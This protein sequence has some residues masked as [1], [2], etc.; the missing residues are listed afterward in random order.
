MSICLY[1][2]PLQFDKLF[3]C[4]T[5]TLLHCVQEHLYFTW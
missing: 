1:V 5:F 3:L 2:C 4:I